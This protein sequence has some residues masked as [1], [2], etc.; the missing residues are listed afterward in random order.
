VIC[1]ACYDFYTRTLLGTLGRWLDE[2]EAQMTEEERQELEDAAAEPIFI[3]FPGFT[4]QLESAPYRGTDP[5]WQ[6]YVKIS[7]NQALQKSIR[8]GFCL[9]QCIGTRLL[10]IE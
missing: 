8:C 7:K 4:K 1:Y 9:G 10:I 3:P 6:A 5:E 2:E